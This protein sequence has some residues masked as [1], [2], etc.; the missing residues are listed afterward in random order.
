MKGR[1]PGR[2]PG[3]PAEREQWKLRKRRQRQRV[4]DGMA[5]YTIVVDEVNVVVKLVDAGF[6]KRDHA[7]DRERIREAIERVLADLELRAE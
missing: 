5:T 6:L 1:A 2:N 4:D 7:D 3:T